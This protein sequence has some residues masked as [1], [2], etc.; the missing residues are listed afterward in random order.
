MG[1]AGEAVEFEAEQGADGAAGRNPLAAGEAG[2]GEQAVEAEASEVRS[3]QEEA[4]EGGAEGARG[5]VE[6]AAVGHRRGERP[7]RAGGA[8]GEFGDAVLLEDAGHVGLADREAGAGQLGGDVEHGELLLAQV[9]DAPVA[10]AGGGCGIGG[11]GSGGREREEGV[12]GVLAEVGEEV[13]D[14][15]GRVGEPVGG[16]GGSEAVD[17]DGAQGFVTALL[18]QAGAEEEVGE[19]VHMNSWKLGTRATVPKWMQ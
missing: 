11:L 16:L 2:L 4:A 3:E 1:L 9:E 10:L 6:L 18:G 17:A 19:V 7:D 14:G 12:V 15:A 13:A 8:P 5:E